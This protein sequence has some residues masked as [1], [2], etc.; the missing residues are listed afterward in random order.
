M[1]ASADSGRGAHLLAAIP[2]PRRLPCALALVAGIGVFATSL[3]SLPTA[4]L[5]PLACGWFGVV[6]AGAVLPRRGPLL[7]T[8]L[9]SITK[10]ATVALAVWAVT[11]PD[12]HLGPHTALDWVP[13]GSLNAGTGLW[14]LAV[15]RGRAR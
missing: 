9:A 1:N 13:L 8:V 15:I 11:H 6:A 14:L 7:L 2:A 10:A 4:A 5:V 3:R 12:S